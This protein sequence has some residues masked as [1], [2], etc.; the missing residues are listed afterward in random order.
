M[1]P[2]TK[3]AI[4]AVA[5][6]ALSLVGFTSAIGCGGG[7]GGGSGWFNPRCYLPVKPPVGGF[8]GRFRNA[9]TVFNRTGVVAEFDGGDAEFMAISD[10]PGFEN[11]TIEPYSKTKTLNLSSGFGRKLFWV[12]FYNY[13][14]VPTVAYPFWVNFSNPNGGRVLGTQAYADGTLLRGSNKKVYAVKGTDLIHIATLADLRKHVGKPILDVE[15]SVIL[16]FAALNAVTETEEEAPAT[17]GQVLG[18]SSIANGTL[19]RGSD[20]KIYVII[21]GKKSHIHSLAELAK[22]VGKPIL[23]VADDVLAQY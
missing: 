20:K 13:C 19:V 18:V 3:T 15:D 6:T 2:S 4:V 16:N 7:G 8:W 1:K 22:Y 9:P 14:K 12:R 21:N 5:V 23:D 11:A 10:S 17:E